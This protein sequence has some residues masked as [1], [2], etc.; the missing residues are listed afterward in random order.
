M[1]QYLFDMEAPA[2]GHDLPDHWPADSDWTPHV[3]GFFASK[4]YEQLQSFLHSERANR[5]IFPLCEDVFRA[6][7]LT[8]YAGTRVVILGQDPYHGTGQAHGLSFSVPDG[9]R[10][11]PSLRNIFKELYADFDRKLPDLKSMSGE[12]TRWAVQGVLLLNTVLTVRES[13]AG[14][15]Q[16]KGWEA[17]TD[18]AIRSLND[19]PEPVV[20]I[21]WGKQAEKKGDL[22][23]AQHTIISS[24]HP[25]PL[26]ASRGFFG[27]RPFSRANH[28]LEQS[29]RKAIDWIE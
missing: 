18:L 1:N 27:S 2:G 8:P 11:P 3:A 20:F 13:D 17:F 24:A 7:A 10:I 22:I 21:L 23:D 28:A 9:E 12:L 25:S 19:H 16:K 6:F 14:S 4:Q 26:S 5:R 15:H 29:G